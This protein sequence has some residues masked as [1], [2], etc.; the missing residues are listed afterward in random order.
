MANSRSKTFHTRHQLYSLQH[1]TSALVIKALLKASSDS[2]IKSI[3]N[4]AVNIQK[5]DVEI[6]RKEKALFRKHRHIIQ[7]LFDEWISI[8]R[9]RQILVRA[10]HSGENLLIPILLNC[11]YKSFGTLDNLCAK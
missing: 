3:C 1:A 9:K 4:I 7:K 10:H 11:A 6:S 2:V 5:G 8:K